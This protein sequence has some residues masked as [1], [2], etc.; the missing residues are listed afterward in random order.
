MGNPGDDNP[1]TEDRHAHA[2][3]ACAS[4]DATKTMSD[5]DRTRAFG[6]IVRPY[7]PS[8]VR[9]PI[10]SPG[11]I[12]ILSALTFMPAADLAQADPQNIQPAAWVAHDLSID[13]HYLPRHY[14]CDEL[15]QKFHDVLLVLGARP[16]LKIITTR[17]ERSSR[18]PSVRLQFSSPELVKRTSA[19]GTAIGAAAATIRLDAGHPAS[20][21]DTD[22]ELMRQIKDRLLAPVSQRIV[23]FNLACS[24]PPSRRGRFNVSVQALQAVNSTARV[25]E[26]PHP[27]PKQLE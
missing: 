20:L 22:C 6:S 16:D 10:S 25:A 4:A 17:C 24:A 23:S 13:L 21:N 9:V 18:S 1:H 8:H 14:S 2:F 26:E 19:R 5:C 3:K 7:R 11:C 27:L 15:W 12:L